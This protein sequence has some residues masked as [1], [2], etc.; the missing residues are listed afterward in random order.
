MLL[1][2]SSFMMAQ[3]SHILKA[4]GDLVKLKEGKDLREALSVSKFTKADGQVANNVVVKAVANPQATPDTLT[5]S[6]TGTNF[7][8][9]SGNVMMQYF[10]APADLTI[11]GAGFA[12]S[13]DAGAATADVSVRLLKLNWTYDQLISFTAA[14]NIGVYPSEGD[15]L[16]GIDAFGEAAT[17]NWTPAADLAPEFQLP[18]WADNADPGANTY[19]YDLWSDAGFGW[20]VTP[21]S[22]GAGSYQW[23][24]MSLLGFEPT[25]LQGEV[26]AVAVTHDGSDAGFTDDRIGMYAEDLGIPGWKYYEE[27]RL[28]AGDGW[29]IRQYAWDYAVAVE[30]TGDRPPKIEGVTTLLTTVSTDAQTVEATITDDN[31]GG[32]NAGVASAELMYSTDGTTFTSVA[33]TANGDVFSADVPG[34]SPGTNIS[35]YVMATD[36]EGLTTETAPKS[37]GIFEVVNTNLLVIF[38]G[39]TEGRAAQLAGAYYLLGLV[40][41]FDLWAAYGPVGDFINQYD[42]VLEISAEGGPADDNQAALTA[43]AASGGKVL[44]VVGQEILGYL[45]GYADSAYVAGDYE[46]D[47][48]GVMQSYN[49]V[50]SGADGIN[51]LIPQAGTMYG[52]GLAQWLTSNEFGVDTIWYNPGNILGSDNWMDQFDPRGDIGSEV[53]MHGIAD[54]GEERPVGH[55]YTHASGTEIFFASADPLLYDTDSAWVGA[56][57]LSPLVQFIAEKIVSVKLTDNSVP[58]E[59]TLSQN[60]PNPFNPS[61]SINF[62]IPKSGLTTLKIYNVLG[63]EVA[64]LMNK[65]LTAGS[66][67]VD[68]DARELSSGM[69]IYT[70]TNGDFEISKKMMLLK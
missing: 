1:F 13:D 51:Q 26:F 14:A 5:Y 46:Y 21:V 9:F 35:Y 29:W 19:D 7:G 37:Y 31:P 55:N 16:G 70:I 48:L 61:T 23:V 62:S 65:D 60:Y 11:K 50:V 4:N 30:L 27:G 49:D 57:E 8:M 2:A 45:V 56:S 28:A 59:Y 6:P 18:P 17:G 63:Q 41:N 32:G 3:S 67:S 69:Y 54:G 38:N 10:V 42:A 39:G 68:F 58:R 20:P 24:D 66:Y 36:V 40:E 15:G 43:F 25:V 44:G 33:M 52:D 53:F 34:Q 64:T 47:I 12:C 22:D